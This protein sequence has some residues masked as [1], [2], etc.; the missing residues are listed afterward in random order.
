MG[1]ARQQV[2]ENAWVIA[3]K[4][5]LDSTTSEDFKNRVQK[6]FEEAG[7][8]AHFLLDMAGVKYL[9]SVG[10][11]ALIGFKKLSGEKSGTFGL[12][13]IQRS[14]KRVLEISRLDFM[15]LRPEQLDPASPFADYVRAQET[16]R[17][18]KRQPPKP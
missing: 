15:E 11:G 10:L 4:G 16:V 12:Y 9:S 8:P 14:V 2:G 6:F 7:A 1:L 3:P 18:P 13:D 5:P 17:A